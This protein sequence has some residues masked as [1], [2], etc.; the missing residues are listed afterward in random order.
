MNITNKHLAGMMDLCHAEV[1]DFRVKFKTHSTFMKFL[2][3]FVQIFN[4]RFMTSFTT[5]IGSTVY[6]SSEEKLLAFQDAYAEVLAHE[7]RHMMDRKKYGTVLYTLMYLSPQIFALLAVLAIG[8]IWNSWFLLALLFLLLLA[9]IPAYG[10][11]HIEMRGYEMSLA[12][13]F[14]RTGR[15]NEEDIER[16]AS[17]FVS[18]NYY[19]MWP[20]KTQVM[21]ELTVRSLEIRSGR[22]LRDPLFRKVHQV[23]S[24]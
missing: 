18:A 17:H 9:P 8:A 2:N 16:V 20:F 22:V 7:L 15:I 1:E 6:F 5:V 21:H 14:W 13:I 11:K 12:V 3:F 4:S 23:F 19:F 10:R 24:R